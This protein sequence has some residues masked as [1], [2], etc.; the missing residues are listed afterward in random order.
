MTLEIRKEREMEF[1]IFVGIPVTVSLVLDVIALVLGNTR[2]I[3]L[4]IISA[5]L[6]IGWL[7]SVRMTPKK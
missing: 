5:G 6:I 2:G 4:A 1:I 3:I 7:S